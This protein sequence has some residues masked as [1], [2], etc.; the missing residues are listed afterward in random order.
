MHRYRCLDGCGQTFTHL[1]PWMLPHKHYNA[2]DVEETLAGE[3]DGKGKAKGTS[4]AE[5]STIR[6]WKRH[7][8]WV[9]PELAAKLESL[10]ALFSHSV[11]SLPSLVEHYGALQRVYRAVSHLENVPEGVSRL[12]RAFHL[13]LAHPLCLG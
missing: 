6:R 1:P 8:S 10:G 7:F 5:E 9:L 2:F 12:S 11:P 4:G 3:A 13:S